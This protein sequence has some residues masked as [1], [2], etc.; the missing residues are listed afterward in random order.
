MLPLA[1]YS[2][3]LATVHIKY[4][5]TKPVR[6]ERVD[7]LAVLAKIGHG[8]ALVN[9]LPLGAEP[10]LSAQLVEVECS[11]PGADFA[12]WVAP[13]LGVPPRGPHRASAVGLRDL[14]LRF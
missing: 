13:V 2:L 12:G 5:N 11:P 10:G 7:A 8:P 4:E 14:L 6:S 1:K 9:V 3:I